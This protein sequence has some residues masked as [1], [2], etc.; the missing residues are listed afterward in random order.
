[1]VACIPV[2][3]RPAMLRLR[4]LNAALVI[5][6]ATSAAAHA[7]TTDFNH[8]VVIGD[9]LSD[10]G[11]ISLSQGA[12]QPSRFTTN[13][14]KVAVEHVADHYGIDLAPSVAGGNDYAFGG[15][16]VA[17]GSIPSMTTQWA[18]YL[19]DNGGHADAHTLYS[20]WGGANDIFYHVKAVGAAATAQ[21]LI[22]QTIQQQVQAALTGGVIQPA[23]VDAFVAQITPTVTQQVLAQVSAAAGVTPETPAQAQAGIA[24][25]AKQELALLGKMHASGAEYALVFNLPDIGK[26]PAAA[27]QGQT[28]QQSL[29]QLS[30]LYNG[31]LAGGLNSLSDQGLNVVPVDVYGLFNE[32]IA[33]PSAF[34]F[35]NVTA[36]ACGA[37][38]SSVQCG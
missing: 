26:T 30:L 29:A 3:R 25:A 32:V 22:E 36:P 2:H 8:M 28:A 37:G 10:N 34:G 21:A 14:G 27:A 18:S 1:M 4:Q 16:R 5:A 15:A 7:G 20:V 23:Q 13:P 35:S 9:S 33:N 12:S 19:G 11:N 38:S 31:V 17:A 24:K 6:L